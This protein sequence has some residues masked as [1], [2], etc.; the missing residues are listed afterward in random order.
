M[1]GVLVIGAPGAGLSDIFEQLGRPF[2]TI[3][4]DPA[5]DEVQYNIGYDIKE[6]ITVE[7]V[8][9]KLGGHS[10][11]RE[12]RYP[13]MCSPS[14]RFSILLRC[15]QIHL[16]NHFYTMYVCLVFIWS[17]SKI[18]ST[19]V[20]LEMPQVNILSKI[21]LFDRSCSFDL[22]FFTQLPDVSR[23][24]EMLNMYGHIVLSYYF[25]IAFSYEVLPGYTSYGTNPQ[26]NYNGDR[27]K[28]ALGTVK[29]SYGA[30]SYLQIPIGP[31]AER[32]RVPKAFYH[33]SE[34]D[35]GMQSQWGLPDNGRLIS[36]NSLIKNNRKEINGIY[37]PI[38]NMDPINLHFITQKTFEKGIDTAAYNNSPEGLLARAKRYG[39]REC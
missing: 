30:P 33:Y 24:L 10:E 8:M 18:L 4:L 6:L 25:I 20:T 39:R 2:I 11:F 19:M 22:E 36:T 15:G 5:N 35:T 31:G 16:R 34:Q 32:L 9:D 27:M 26:L 13:F 3:N 14:C 23:L 12:G 7:D 38:P 29:D 17:I 37:L 21:D 28:F 1:Y